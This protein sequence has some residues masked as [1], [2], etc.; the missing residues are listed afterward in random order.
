M[1]RSLPI[2]AS[3]VSTSP[4]D[5]LD[6]K[7]FARSTRWGEIDKVLEASTPHAPG[8]RREDQRGGAEESHEDDF[9]I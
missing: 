2:A 7:K 6:P 1:P 5:T 4:L 9:P 8:P 3:A